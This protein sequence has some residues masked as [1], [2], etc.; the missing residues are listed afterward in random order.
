[1][2]AQQAVTFRRSINTRF[3]PRV[4]A[5]PPIKLVFSPPGL[6]A[7]E[8]FSLSRFQSAGDH[9]ALAPNRRLQHLLEIVLCH[10]MYTSRPVRGSSCGNGEVFRRGSVGWGGAGGEATGRLGGVVGGVGTQRS[11]DHS[12][13]S[14][15]LF[16]CQ[17]DENPCLIWSD[18]P[19]G[20]DAVRV[21]PLRQIPW[22]PCGG[23]VSTEAAVHKWNC[24][25]QMA[26]AS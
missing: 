21:V 5:S 14:M 6:V 7:C 1:M 16:V 11:C 24:R 19:H 3:Y 18:C 17:E 22:G 13:D 20:F 25:A 8:R 4:L 12:F 9:A 15:E 26:T 2:P 23:F 10:L